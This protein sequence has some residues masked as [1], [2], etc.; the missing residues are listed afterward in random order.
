MQQNLIIFILLSH[1]N[2]VKYKNGFKIK[3]CMSEQKN[4][5]KII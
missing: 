3:I 2:Y 4:Q 1:K 5:T